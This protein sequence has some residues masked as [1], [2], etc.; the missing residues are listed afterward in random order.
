MAVQKVSKKLDDDHLERI[1]AFALYRCNLVAALGNNVVME[2]AQTATP[3][4]PMLRT[5]YLRHQ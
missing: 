5:N 2:Y 3:K 4:G 1:C